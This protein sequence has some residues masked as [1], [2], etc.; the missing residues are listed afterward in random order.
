MR[1][2]KARSSAVGRDANVRMSR[3]SHGRIERGMEYGATVWSLLRVWRRRNAG[4]GVERGG[5]WASGGGGG[6][7]GGSGGVER[8]VVVTVEMVS[9][10]G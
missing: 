1:G 4:H 10:C 3:G 2:W 6:G 5:R 7:R 9:R 8:T